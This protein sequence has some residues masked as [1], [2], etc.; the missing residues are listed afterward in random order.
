MSALSGILWLCRKQL[1]AQLLAQSSEL[2]RIAAIGHFSS[3]PRAAVPRRT[4]RSAQQI[5][6]FRCER[7]RSRVLQLAHRR[8]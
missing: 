7:A 5:I 1:G 8:K 6:T 2:D 3:E 4:F